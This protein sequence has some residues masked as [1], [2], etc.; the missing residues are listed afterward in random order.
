MCNDDM[1]SYDNEVCRPLL[2]EKGR[3]L[4]ISQFRQPLISSPLSFLNPSLNSVLRV[5]DYVSRSEKDDNFIG[6]EIE[7]IGRH[8]PALADI[9][10]GERDEY[11][12]QTLFEVVGQISSLSRVRGTRVVAVVGAGHIKV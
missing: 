3:K 7:Q 10:I 4:F 5:K 12:A 9:L 2:L 6:D 8:L 1:G 11:I